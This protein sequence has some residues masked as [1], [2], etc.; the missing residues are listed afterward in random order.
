MKLSIGPFVYELLLANSP[1]ELET[2]QVKHKLQGYSNY[3]EE[4]KS[5]FLNP[6]ELVWFDPEV[7]NDENKLYTEIFKEELKIKVNTFT[8]YEDSLKFI[9]KD[10]RNRRLL[11]ICCGSRG[12]EL[13]EAIKMDINVIFLYIFSF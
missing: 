8:K 1:K 13:C 9:Q 2:L 11:V 12:L 4:L 3:I 10:G 7:L 6:L 5:K